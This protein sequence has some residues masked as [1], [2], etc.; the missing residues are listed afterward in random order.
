MFGVKIKDVQSYV[1]K[2]FH[3]FV[4]EIKNVTATKQELQSL[5]G[6]YSSLERKFKKLVEHLGVEYSETCSK[7]FT[8][9]KKTK[10]S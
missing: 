2:K 1:D 10:K 7:G 6:Q 4:K 3:G 5:Q 9:V 8:K